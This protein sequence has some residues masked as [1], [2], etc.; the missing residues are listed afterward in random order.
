MA[1][2]QN[3]NRLP[4]LDTLRA[5]AILIVIF[6]HMVMSHQP[7]ERPVL[8]LPD[9]FAHNL[10]AFA[11]VGVDLFFV[12]SGFLIAGI[13]RRELERA[14]QI[15]AGNFLWRRWTRTFP[16]YFATL[17]V[18]IGLNWLNARH[19][20]AAGPTVSTFVPHYFLFLQNYFT[21]MTSFGWSWS[22]CVEEHFYIALPFLVIVV[23]KLS[24]NVSAVT[25]LRGIAAAA[26]FGTCALRL[27]EIQNAGADFQW[28]R[29]IRFR[30][31]AHLDGITMGVF[32]ATLARPQNV[33]LCL[34]GAVVAVAGLVALSQVAENSWLFQNLG[35]TLISLA[36]GW[37]VHISAG[38]NFWSRLAVPGA[39][40]VAD[41]SYSLYLLHMIVIAFVV[42]RMPGQP[43]LVRMAV[44]LVA[45]FAAAAAM[46]YAVELPFL[47]VR[48][49]LNPFARKSPAVAPPGPAA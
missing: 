28:A 22:L 35:F 34:A 18:I 17:G 29:D 47:K 7:G 23:R 10:F 25:L 2:N 14:P 27:V 21:P 45:C 41:L 49:K 48:D 1:A 26:F 32:I 9:G 31:H 19:N 20:A 30:T 33:R 46:R 42:R 39:R 11:G 24:P 6:H 4:A 16:A 3:D 5:F 15:H 36:F 38:G 12:L 13:L 40:V 44:V 37:L 43:T 8:P